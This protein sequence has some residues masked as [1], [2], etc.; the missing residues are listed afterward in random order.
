MATISI[1]MALY[2]HANFVSECIRSI[3][4][5]TFSDWELVIVDDAS[6][7]S[8]LKV[9][10]PIM[11]TD[12]RI[13][14]SR[15]SVNR[16]PSAARNEA[17]RLATGKFISFVDAD[18]MLTKS[19]LEMRLRALDGSE[20]LWVHGRAYNLVNGKLVKDR[21][22]HGN[23]KKFHAKMPEPVTRYSLAVHSNSVMVKRSFYEKLGLFDEDL[24][25]GEEQD[26][27]KRALAFGYMPLYVNDFVCIYRHHAGQ[28]RFKKGA[29]ELKS[30][31]FKLSAKRLAIR[32][33]EGITKDN[34]IL[35]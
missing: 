21:D 5:Q 34:T 18:D 6:T 4:K 14:Y 27:W 11:E 8:P 10:K 31:C 28:T 24:R 1:I 7:D 17:I 2:N 25:Y 13:R 35:L 32:L 20:S 9:L 29:R 33:A 19:S 16:G 26:V 23:W 15:F 3:R 30:R 12:A 22:F